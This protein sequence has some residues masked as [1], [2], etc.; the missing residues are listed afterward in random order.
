[1]PTS[2]HFPENW[3]EWELDPS[4]RSSVHLWTKYVPIDTEIGTTAADLLTVSRGQPSVNLVKN[5]S[6]EHATIS[7]FTAS[8]SAISQSSAQASTGSNSLL[9]NP[10]NSAAGEGFY[11]SDKF[12]GHTEGTSI[13]AQCEVRGASASGDVK[14]AIQDSDGVELAASDTHSLT[15]SFARISVKWDIL[16]RVAATYRIAVVSVAQHNINFYVDKIMIEQRRDGNLSDYVDGAQGI[17]YEWMGTAHLSESKRR[18]G[19]S[20]IRGFKLKNGHGSQTAN[21]A[22]DTTATAAG[23]TSTG[24]L[25]KAGET[26][27]TNWPINAQVKI[28]AI[29]SGASTQIY[30]VIWGVHGG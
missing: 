8:G 21:I 28:S 30:G 17:N 10:A 7:E 12:A 2:E 19:L 27:E 18:P 3:P 5:P 15:T 22:I 23:T 1:M 9:V 24:I 16:E 26:I 4:T 14:I 29:A 6:I 13:V 20:A 25:L 11:W